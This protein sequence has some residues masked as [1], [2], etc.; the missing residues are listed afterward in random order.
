[1]EHVSLME[2]FADPQLFESLNMGEKLIGGAITTLVGMGITFIILILLALLIVIM[3]RLIENPHKKSKEPVPEKAATQSAP[4]AAVTTEPDAGQLIAVITS[5]IAALEGNKVTS[6]LVVRK[7]NRTAGPAL[8]WSVAGQQDA[9]A[10]R[11][12]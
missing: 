6:N 10:S 2:R 7:I 3:D 5:V 8:A 1:M 4:A 9:I 12:R 11:K